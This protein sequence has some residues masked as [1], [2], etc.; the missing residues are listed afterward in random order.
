[1]TFL[2]LKNIE[3]ESSLLSPVEREEMVLQH[4]AFA[5]KLAL[6]FLRQW[7]AY[8]AHDDIQSLSDIGLCET[9]L[10]FRKDRGAQFQTLLYFYVKNEFVKE[11]RRR[12]C[13]NIILFPINSENHCH[14][15]DEM[16]TIERFLENDDVKSPEDEY[17]SK[18]LQKKCR[19]VFR[20]LSSMERKVII[21][22][23]IFEQ[24]VANVAR[25]LGYSRG[26]I[27]EIKKKAISKMKPYMMEYQ[28]A[29]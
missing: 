28:K 29:A 18:E 2:T 6:T 17:L 14:T 22:V 7:G 5:Y 4:R 19:K 24:K 20:N 25:D 12:K 10:R 27:S 9:A 3:A 15:T 13:S 11:I 21:A 16:L 8:L 1:M 23:C 26:H